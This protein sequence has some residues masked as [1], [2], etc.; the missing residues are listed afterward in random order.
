MH[1]SA[2]TRHQCS[3][4]HIQVRDRSVFIGINPY[5][6]AL[7]RRMRDNTA[8]STHPDM[9]GVSWGQSAQ[10]ATREVCF[11]ILLAVTQSTPHREC[12]TTPE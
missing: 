6:S 1:V 9:R 7:T 11:A 5:A 3:F 8:T 12:S 10:T 2:F 4:V